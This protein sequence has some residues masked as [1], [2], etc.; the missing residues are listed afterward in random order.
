MYYLV[1]SLTPAID[2][3][4]DRFLISAEYSEKELGSNSSGMEEETIVCAA[5]ASFLYVVDLEFSSTFWA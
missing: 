2:T 5:I 4:K 1:A 3:V